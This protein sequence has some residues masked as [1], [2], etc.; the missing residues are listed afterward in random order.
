MRARGRKLQQ[1]VVRRQ[2]SVEYEE[3]EDAMATGLFRE[4]QN[5]SLWP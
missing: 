1:G 5:K 3:K 2:G 4:K